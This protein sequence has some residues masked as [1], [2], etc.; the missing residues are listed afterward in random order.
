MTMIVGYKGW[1]TAVAVALV[2]V[3][4][5][6]HAPPAYAQGAGIPA[7]PPA[8]VPIDAF[9]VPLI[10][11]NTPRGVLRLTIALEVASI[12]AGAR[13]GPNQNRLRQAWIEA[14]SRQFASR[15]SNAREVDLDQIGNALLN[16][17]QRLFGDDVVTGL[18]FQRALIERQ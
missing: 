13:I 15:P 8:T 14:L 5:G 6:A 9:A 16:R 2:L 17:A 11:R 12:E 7:N 4:T 1:L 10:N 18:L 3:T